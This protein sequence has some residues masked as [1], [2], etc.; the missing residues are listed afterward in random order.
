MGLDSLSYTAP[1]RIKALLC[2]LGRIKRS[3]FLHFVERLQSSNVVRLGDVTPDTKPNRTL[4]SPQG[5]PSGQ[6][7]YDLTT[8]FDREHEYLEGFELYRRTFLVIAIADHMEENDSEALSTQLEELKFLYPRALYHVCLIFDSPPLVSITPP[9]TTPHSKDAHDERPVFIPVPTQKEAR[10]N[11]MRTI[12][13]DITTV[14]LS[15]LGG[16]ARSVQGLPTIESPLS[17][18]GQPGGPLGPRDQRMSMPAGLLGSNLGVGGTSA[19]AASKRM[20]MTGFGSAS[21]SERTRNKGKGRIVIA[22]AGL[23]LMTGRLPDALKEFIEGAEAARTS[24]DHLW[25]GKALEGI[26]ICMVLLLHLKVDFQIPSIPLPTVETL[27]GARSSPAGSKPGTPIPG[28]SGDLGENYSVSPD[29][30]FMLLNEHL[31]IILNQYSRSSII[32]AESIPQICFSETVIRFCKFRASCYLASG[33]NDESLAHIVLNTPI[34]TTKMWKA[35]PIRS[36]IA[37][38]VMRAYPFPVENMTALDATRVLSGIASVLGAIGARRRK[39]LVTRELVKILIPG[40]IQARVVGAAEVGVHP[41]AG[42]SA[43]SGGA[44][45][46]SPLDLGEGD[47]ESGIMELLEDLCRAYGVLHTGTR[48]D[49]P[50]ATDED[51][52]DALRAAMATADVI[53][54]QEIRSFGWPALKIHVLRNCT[55]LCEALPDFHGVLRFTAQ[56]LRTADNDLTKEEQ[57]RLSTTISRTVGAARK[58]GLPNVEAGYWDQFL[59]RDVEVVEN[60]MWRPPIAHSKNELMDADADAPPSAPIE[61]DKNP[62]IYNPFLKKAEAATVDQVLVTGEAAEFRVTLQNPFEFDIEVENV[63]LDTTGVEVDVQPVGVIINPFRTYQIAVYA[64]P[65]VGGSIKIL[66]CKIK[67]FGCVERSFPIFTEGLDNRERDIKT[68]RYGLKAAE[69]KNTR[70][71]SAISATQ[72]SS[73]VP[74]P[75]HPIPKTLSLTVVDPQPLL[76]VK[77]TSLSQSALMVLEGERRVFDITFNNLSATDVDLLVFSFRDSTTGRIQQALNEKGNSPAE[78]YELE[79][80]LA[81]KRA[82]T[83]HKR[84]KTPRKVLEMESSS[85]EIIEVEDGASSDGAADAEVKAEDA[86]VEA[87]AGDADAKPE[88]NGKVVKQN[89]EKTI[90]VPGFGRATF[91]IMVLGKPGLT[92]GSVQADYGHLGM[93]RNEVTDKFYTRQVV[94]PVTVTVNASIEL[95][96]VDFVPFSTD[97]QFES[98]PGGTKDGDERERAEGVGQEGQFKELFRRMGVKDD[99]GEYC[100]MLLDLRNAWPQALK[101][102]LYARDSPATDEDSE[103]SWKGAFYAEDVLQ[104]GHTSRV[105]L[106][107]KRI[108]LAEPTA[109]IPSLSASQRQ[110]VVSTAKVTAEQERQTREAFWYREEVLKYIR[111]TW[112]EVGTTRVGDIELRGIRLSQRM[113]ETI[114]VEDIGINIGVKESNSEDMVDGVDPVMRRIGPSKYLVATDE[115]LTLTTKLTNRT[116]RTVKPLLRLLPALR[117]QAT[118]IALD[119]T[120]RLAFNGLLQQSLPA[121]KPQEEFTVEMGF[122]ALCRGEFEISGSVEEIRTAE[123]SPDDLKDDGELGPDGIPVDLISKMIGRKTWV[124]REMCVIVARDLD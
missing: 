102:K 56:L 38:T 51:G 40:L 73:R 29:K 22:V 27:K 61:V 100:L 122:V 45:G 116:N 90:F 64:T 118:T 59:L 66:G 85:G 52:A 98:I 54:E 103:E 104:A 86:D 92:H 70:P 78:M 96:R 34:P 88:V 8:S 112:E 71:I 26:G 93:H 37:T 15:E 16:F 63:A 25:Y 2:P 83:W 21:A 117:N 24:S 107:I 1:S 41:A 67:V 48:E 69:P 105:I 97:L 57:M 28:Q 108:F 76:V 123:S 94:F 101:I 115:F 11:S 77:S 81:K 20:T 12:M 30:V 47:A 121:L 14:L 50:V 42:L 44:L 33:L 6:I 109:A 19:A 111:G 43:I 3:R 124:S 18:D 89:Q 60:S 87:K 120:R 106:P 99:P 114:R 53:A 55:A 68:K 49:P 72:R 35:V 9:E 5:F 4:F 84:D 74:A 113:V 17:T 10:N 46:G 23:Y 95:A 110:F 79:L 36:E 13:C 65:K 82:F 119:L 91:E 32:P 31:D 7:V 39:A 62:F 80:M 58:L 75:L